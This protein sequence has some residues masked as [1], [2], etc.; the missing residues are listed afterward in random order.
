MLTRETTINQV[1]SKNESEDTSMYFVM[2]GSCVVIKCLFIESRDI[3]SASV[4]FPDNDSSFDDV[5]KTNNLGNQSDSD[6]A[7]EVDFLK[8][9]K[10]ESDLNAQKQN[11]AG[12]VNKK[13]DESALVRPGLFDQLDL[14]FGRGSEKKGMLE[15]IALVKKVTNLAAKLEAQQEK[16]LEIMKNSTNS[17]SVYMDL[18]EKGARLQNK[19]AV[20]MEVGRLKEGDIF[21]LRENMKP[22]DKQNQT[23]L[24]KVHRNSFYEETKLEDKKLHVIYIRFSV[25]H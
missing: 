7:D 21:N 23:I 13:L 20:F 14:T 17:F 4:S 5:I 9:Q 22:V 2:D 18:T 16:E 3:N 24:G 12:A 1:V 6:S 10:E 15:E 11:A 25:L 19:I 8:I